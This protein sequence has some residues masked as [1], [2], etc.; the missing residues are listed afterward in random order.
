MLADMY[1]FRM[2]FHNWCDKGARS[3]LEALRPVLRPGT[4]VVAIEYVMPPV[5]TAPPYAELATR[6]LDN[7]MY[8]LMKG[9]V[10][11][12]QEFKDLFHNVEPALKFTSFKQGALKATHDP[13]CH[14]V[15]EWIYDPDGQVVVNS[16]DAETATSP[17]TGLSIDTGSTPQS[18]SM[19][20]SSPSTPVEAENPG[21]A[22]DDKSED[23]TTL[24]IAQYGS[25]SPQ[26]TFPIR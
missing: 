20:G 1:L 14:S 9:K 24:R 8:S 25:E 21:L 15:L 4:R 19:A 16:N 12:L 26:H 17:T 10:R 2:V 22:I 5:G 23:P 18:P 11:E 7:V 6:R 13:K 3:I